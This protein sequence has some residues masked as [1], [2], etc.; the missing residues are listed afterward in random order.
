MFF[1]FL[2]GL[3]FELGRHTCKVGILTLEHTSS[4]SALFWADQ[5]QTNK[6]EF[7]GHAIKELVQTVYMPVLYSII[8]VIH[9]NQQKERK[10]ERGNY[11][12]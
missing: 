4:H 8:S 11:E 1:V 9:W 7:E 10:K 12:N 2:V 6:K 5:N 3:R